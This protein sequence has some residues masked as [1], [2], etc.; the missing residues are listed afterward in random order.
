MILLHS[1]RL[2]DLFGLSIVTLTLTG[3]AGHVMVADGRR[4]SLRS[5][6]FRS[7]VDTVFREQN[8]L[9][10]ELAFALDDAATEQPQLAAAEQTLLEACAGLNELA[11]AQRDQKQLSVSRRLALAKSV[12]GCERAAAAVAQVL[13]Q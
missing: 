12:P 9:G 6:E 2:S 7:Y 5:P 8:R 1:R 11:A 4:I 3:C 13:D 10:D